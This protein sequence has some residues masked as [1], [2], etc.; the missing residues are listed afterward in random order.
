MSRYYPYIKFAYTPPQAP[1]AGGIPPDLMQLMMGGG[2]APMPPGGGMPPDMGG[3]PPDMGAMPPGGGVPPDMGGM[4]P[5]A[6][7]NVTYDEASAISPDVGAASDHVAQ[8]QAALAVLS[9]GVKQ[10]RRAIDTIAN[11]QMGGGAAPPGGSAPP[12]EQKTAYYRGVPV[13]GKSSALFEL[14]RA[15]GLQ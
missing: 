2:G 3:M 10:L 15:L 11:Q 9:E 7:G 14:M 5:E 8:L 1:G 12:P 13:S 6:G 4:P